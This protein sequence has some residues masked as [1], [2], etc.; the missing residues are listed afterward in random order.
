MSEVIDLKKYYKYSCKVMQL[1]IFANIFVHTVLTDLLTQ[2]CWKLIYM[3]VIGGCMPE[4]IDLTKNSI[5]N[6]KFMQDA[7]YLQIFLW[8]QF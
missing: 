4:I 1:A 2:F 6:C 7:I 3:Y 5:G 8:A